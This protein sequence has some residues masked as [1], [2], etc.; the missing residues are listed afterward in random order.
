MSW[1]QI[2]KRG[3]RLVGSA[4]EGIG[5]T[6]MI[7]AGQW[8]QVHWARSTGKNGSK[9]RE[10]WVGQFH[11]LAP[12]QSDSDSEGSVTGSQFQAGSS[13]PGGGG[14]WPAR[15][16]MKYCGVLLGNDVERHKMRIS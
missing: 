14:A 3:V 10:R 5:P 13:I 15:Q 6:N 8:S 16:T 2:K 1:R 11:D 9:K 12:G 7:L 4:G